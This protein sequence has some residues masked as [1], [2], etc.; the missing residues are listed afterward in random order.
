MSSSSSSKLRDRLHEDGFVVI[1]QI[2]SADELRTLRAAAARATE[3]ARTGQWPH[4]RT[5]GKQFPPWPS[6]PGPEGIWGVQGL[7]NPDLAGSEIFAQSY[8]GDAVLGVA[9]ELMDDC[10]DDDLVM[11]LF[12]MLVRPERDFAL[13]WHR[14]D[15]PATATAD[16]EMARLREPEWHTQWNLAL[17]D[18][19]SLVAVPGSHARARTDAERAADPFAADMPGQ[20]IV[21]LDAGDVV[22]YNNNI[23]HRGVYDS[24]KER[25][26]LHGSVGH[27][28]GSQ[29]RARNV[30]Q[31]GVGKWVDR[32]DFSSLGEKERARAEGMRARLVKLGT[33]SGDVGYSH[34]D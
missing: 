5:V 21:H 26:S 17:Y 28:G 32:C 13:R 7:L 3:L 23:L 14:D 24:T 18:D 2:L 30:L 33:E 9:K 31:H 12:N 22:F 19:D 11:E 6:T 1:R 8:F 34:Q 4:I 25:M 27:A 10:G 29:L 20:A 16:E 15:V